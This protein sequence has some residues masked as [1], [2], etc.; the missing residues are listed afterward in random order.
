MLNLRILL[1]PFFD[2]FYNV[3]STSVIDS[4]VML[5]DI[6]LSPKMYIAGK[7]YKLPKKKNLILES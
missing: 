3:R 1:S 5:L 4:C 2:S 7:L 6:R